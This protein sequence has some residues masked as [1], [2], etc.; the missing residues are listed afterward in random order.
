MT[1]DLPEPARFYEHQR[2]AYLFRQDPD[3]IARVVSVRRAL[4][5]DHAAR[6]MAPSLHGT[7]TQR[8]CSDGRE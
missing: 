7:V 6:Y 1:H 8:G 2:G 4:G 5:M 3:L